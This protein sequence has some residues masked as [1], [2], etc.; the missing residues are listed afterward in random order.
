MTDKK[1]FIIGSRGSKLSLA[2]SSY[3]KNLLIKS[4]LRFNENSI[5]IKIIKTSGDI[6]QN[7]KISDIGGKGVFCKQKLE[8]TPGLQCP[9]QQ[10][11]DIILILPT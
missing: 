1:K 8:K 2:Y 5:E 3:V 6:F 4:N 10:L 11:G 7:R 9:W